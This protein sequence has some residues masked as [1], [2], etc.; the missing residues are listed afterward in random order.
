MACKFQ[1]WFDV[2]LC[3]CSNGL[4][5]CLVKLFTSVWDNRSIPQDWKDI[6]LNGKEGDLSLCDNWHGISL[7]KVVGKVFANI[8]QSR[9]SGEFRYLWLL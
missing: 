2:F 5:E 1:L 8:F 6:L 7:L 3:V 4:L 9:I